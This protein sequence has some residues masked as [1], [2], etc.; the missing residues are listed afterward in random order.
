MEDY[1]RLNRVASYFGVKSKQELAERIVAQNPILKRT[2]N[3]PSIKSLYAYFNGG[4]GMEKS[5]IVAAARAFKIEQSVLT[6]GKLYGRDVFSYN[7]ETNIYDYTPDKE[8]EEF[9]NRE[10]FI[11][12]EGLEGIKIRKYDGAV[13]AGSFGV[14]DETLITNTTL[15][16]GIFNGNT[17]KNTKHLMAFE[18]AGDSMSPIIDERNW[19]VI[20]MVDGRDYHPVDG[21]YL[22]NI[23]SSYQIKRLQFLGTQGVEIISENPKYPIKNSLK[24]DTFEI[25]GKLFTTIKIGS[26]LALK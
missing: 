14:M 16:N 6:E 4:R 13:G 5:I 12:D 24:C 1:E 11:Y 25:I 18:V 21:I 7:D 2:G 23:N 9:T 22:C 19:V 20:D 15:P 3:I 17:P 10:K 8:K 26:G